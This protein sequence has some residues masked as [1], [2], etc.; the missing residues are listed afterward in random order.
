MADTAY[1]STKL[2]TR[3]AGG[4]PAAA[5]GASWPSPLM[6]APWRDALRAADY[7]PAARRVVLVQ[8]TGGPGEWA[9]GNFTVGGGAQEYPNS[10]SWR[11]VA[12]G[13]F[14]LAPGQDHWL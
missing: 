1:K 2:P 13:R 8:Q 3:I 14:M 4:Q 11:T 9:A 5:R 12:R 6:R 10:S 7:I